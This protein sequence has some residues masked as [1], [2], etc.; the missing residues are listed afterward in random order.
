MKCSRSAVLFAAV[1][2]SCF[3]A[4]AQTTRLDHGVVSQSKKFG[5]YWES[6]LEP[7]TPPL[8]FGSVFGV[9]TSNA[10]EPETI[11]RVEADRSQRI[12]FG[13]KARVEVLAEPNTYSITFGQIDR[14]TALGLLF[15]REKEADGWTQIATPGWGL[16]TLGI[17]GGDVITM[18]LLKNPATG[19]KVVDYITVQEPP[20]GTV[21]TFGNVNS[22]AREFAFVTG[23]PR[24][25]RQD[26]GELRIRAGRVSINGRLEASTATSNAEVSGAVVWFYLPQHGRFLLSLTAH[27]DLGFRKAGEVRGSKLSFTAGSDVFSLVSSGAIAP[28]Q[29]AFNLYV[30][31]DPTWKPDYPFADPSGFIM[32]AA[33]RA[34]FLIRK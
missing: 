19:Q 14:Q 15:P 5:F 3:P 4:F 6:R 31:H 18:D 24:D 10:Q 25:F 13:Y 1:V 22:P 16:G 9:A 17:H 20:R 8:D 26:D 33:D 32:G 12:F 30:L 29:S 34:E 23:A 28:T 11:L 27:P 2:W 21:I 7:S